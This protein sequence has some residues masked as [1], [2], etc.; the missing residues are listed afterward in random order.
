M[1]VE[2]EAWLE[3]ERCAWERE[4]GALGVHVR[5]LEYA[6]AVHRQQV[7]ELELRGPRRGPRQEPRRE[8]EAWLEKERCAGEFEYAALGVHIRDLEDAEAAHRQ[9]TVELERGLVVGQGE[10]GPTTTWASRPRP[11]SRRSG[12]PGSAS[13]ARS[14]CTSGTWRAAS[15]SSSPR[16]L[17]RGIYWF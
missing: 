14:G 4:Y 17:E 13:T 7:L 3:K 12:A 10:Q 9:Q 15:R 1:G 2:A 6:E 8:T 16:R 11:S 5:D